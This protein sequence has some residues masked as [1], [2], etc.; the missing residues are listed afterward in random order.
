MRRDN[1][2]RYVRDGIE[3]N[4]GRFSALHVPVRAKGLPREV[5]ERW[6]EPLYVNF[7]SASSDAAVG[8]LWNEMTAE[9]V[10][11]LLSDF[12]W[13]PRCVGGY[14]VALRDMHGFTDVLGKLLLRSDVRF[15]GE[16]YCLALAQLNTPIARGFLDE[17]LSYYLTRP[18]LHFDQGSAMGAVA[19]LDEVNGTEELGKFVASWD[20]FVGERTNWRLEHVC[21]SFAR[22]M[23]RVKFLRDKWGKP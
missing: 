21:E 8:E 6:V 15:A 3:P 18:D 12:N 5:I 4:R 13:R 22:R 16:S 20:E 10:A 2:K 7:F 11:L 17:Y 1:I 9:V 23:Q 14:L 19:Y